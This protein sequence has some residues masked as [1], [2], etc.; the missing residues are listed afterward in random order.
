MLVQRPSAPINSR[1]P[2]ERLPIAAQRSVVYSL[3]KAGLIEEAAVDAAEPGWRT[4]ELWP[5]LGDGGLS[6]AAYRGGW[7]P[8]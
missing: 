6:E 4:D 7:K 3:L 1:I 8:A 5:N 2:P